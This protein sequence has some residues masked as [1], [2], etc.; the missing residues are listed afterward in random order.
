MNA[1]AKQI[2]NELYNCKKCEH[3]KVTRPFYFDIND[4]KKVMLITLAPGFQAVNRQLTSVRFFRLLCLALYGPQEDIAE[5]VKSMIH[6]DIYW[7]HYHKCYFERTSSYPGDVPDE[8]SNIYLKRELMVLNPKLIVII[9]PEV[10]RRLLGKE[11]NKGQLLEDEIYDFKVISANLPVTGVENEYVELREKL[12]YLVA[13]VDSSPV[14]E[15]MLTISLQASNTIAKHAEFELKGLEAFWQRISELHSCS[16]VIND[17]DELWYKTIIIPKWLGYSFITL[18]QAIIEDQLKTAL[19]ADQ[20]KKEL[21][22]KK[23]DQLLA[24]LPITNNKLYSDIKQLKMLRNCI[25]HSG[26]LLDRNKKISF[27]GVKNEMGT[28]IV[29]KA[30]CETALCLVRTFIE[31]LICWYEDR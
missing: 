7:T 6:R 8:C 24:Q 28:I 1:E 17:I 23:M 9:V 20:N 10:S 5:I 30:G 16:D 31:D 22:Y 13:P 12:Q 29:T 14:P 21:T 25:V 19:K 11:P 15:E 2:S 3:R 18:C 27:E 4:N 26:G